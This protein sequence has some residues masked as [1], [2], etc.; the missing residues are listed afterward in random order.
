VNRAVLM[1]MMEPP[2]ELEAQFHDWYDLELVPDHLRVPG[3]IS[4]SRWVCVDGWPRHMAMYDLDSLA[5]LGSEAYRSITA[6]RFSAWSKWMLARVLGRERLVWGQHNSS[7][8]GTGELSRGLVLMRF[9][10][11]H[12]EEA[13]KALERLEIPAE[14]RRRVFESARSPSLTWGHSDAESAVILDAP[15]LS[16]IPTWAATQLAA[17]LGGLVP[18]LVGVWRYTRYIPSQRPPTA[19]PE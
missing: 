2:R 3:I 12:A 14:C 7:P 6:E 17:A 4:G 10:G 11:R 9:R 13:E 8:A 16:L 18:D 1:V 15:A 5:V 19:P